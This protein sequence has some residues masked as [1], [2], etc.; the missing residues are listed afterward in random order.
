MSKTAPWR[1][2]RCY[3]VSVRDAG[4]VGLL[5][6]PFRH[7]RHALAAEPDTRRKANE[8]NSWSHFYAFGTCKMPNGARA[9]LLNDLVGYNDRPHGPREP[10]AST[11]TEPTAFR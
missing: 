3:Y 8:V 11:V 9:G 1:E 4:R 10:V 2:N 5:A 7:H 6:G